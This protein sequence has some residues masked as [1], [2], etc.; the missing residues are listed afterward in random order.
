MAVFNDLKTWEAREI[1]ENYQ[2][3]LNT[4]ELNKS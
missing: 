2:V 3:L 4:K 1:G